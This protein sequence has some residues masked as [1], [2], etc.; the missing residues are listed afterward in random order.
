[1]G[2]V[3]IFYRECSNVAG[4][5]Y[6]FHH[7]LPIKVSHT[8]YPAVA[9][10]ILV[11]LSSIAFN[12][13]GMLPLHEITLTGRSTVHLDGI[14]RPETPAILTIMHL[15]LQAGILGDHQA[16]F[17]IIVTVI[18]LPDLPQCGHSESTMNTE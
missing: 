16:L 8:L 11:N 5:P 9:D 12:L 2:F 14:L 4:T 10:I 1:M 18:I 15:P 6:V 3:N 13:R 17:K 7:W